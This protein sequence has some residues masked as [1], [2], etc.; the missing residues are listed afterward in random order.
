MRTAVARRSLVK[1]AKCSWAS[2]APLPLTDCCPH[3]P[4][5]DIGPAELH[6]F[7]CCTGLHHP[8]ACRR[9]GRHCCNSSCAAAMRPSL[10]RQR[11]SHSRNDARS[12]SV[13]SARGGRV[14]LRGLLAETGTSRCEVAYRS[15]YRRQCI[16]L[17]APV[18]LSRRVLPGSSVPVVSLQC[19]HR[20][21]CWC[22][23]TMRCMVTRGVRR[24]KR[25]MC[26]TTQ[27]CSSGSK[28]PRSYDTL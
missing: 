9:L 18:R 23:S 12:V 5:V 25:L 4:V 22:S 13:R 14:V 8:L 19:R 20:L 26:T 6:T 16:E 7:A 3:P 10:S 1:L 21:A 24:S 11:D 28:R 15:A 17:C 27:W 2:T